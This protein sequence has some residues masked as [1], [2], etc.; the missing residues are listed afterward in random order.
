MEQENV[1]SYLNGT[2]KAELI[3]GY[4]YKFLNAIIG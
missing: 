1:D 2:D 4:Y 3:A